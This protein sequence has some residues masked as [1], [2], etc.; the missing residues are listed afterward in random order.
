MK[1]RAVFV[2]GRLQLD[3][4]E[5]EGG[6]RRSRPK[7]VAQRVTFVGRPGDASAPT[8]GDPTETLPDWVTVPEEG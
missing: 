4:W 7:V 1:G 5:T 2:E 3:Q 6:E 8:H